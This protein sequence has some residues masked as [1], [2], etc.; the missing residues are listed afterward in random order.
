MTP[1]QRMTL[2][3]V[4]RVMASP[5]YVNTARVAVLAH[6]VGDDIEA[7]WGGR[8]FRADN[9]FALDSRLID[10]GVPV[11]N[12]FC[13]TEDAWANRYDYQEKMRDE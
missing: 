8:L 12:L 7:E 2:A 1:D 13:L 6:E 11:H 3:D 10:A 4:A 9:C 5:E